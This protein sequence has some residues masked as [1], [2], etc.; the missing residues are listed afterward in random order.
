MY[1]GRTVNLKQRLFE[2]CRGYVYSTRN[3]R[4]LELKYYEAYDNR[5]ASKDRE[6]KLKSF[7]SSYYGLIKRLKIK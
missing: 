1:I 3:R 5:G 7:G 2:H 4:P 6:K